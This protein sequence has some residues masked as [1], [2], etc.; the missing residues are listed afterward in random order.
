M[1]AFVVTRVGDAADGYGSYQIL[2]NTNEGDYH[3]TTNPCGWDADG[4]PPNLA[5][6]SRAVAAAQGLRPRV[7]APVPAIRLAAAAR[8]V[9]ATRA[10]ATAAPPATARPESPWS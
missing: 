3:A 6:W 5:R 2:E 9:P 8:V 10:T 7:Q 1:K 4:V